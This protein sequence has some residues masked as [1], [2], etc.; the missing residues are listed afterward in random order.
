MDLWVVPT[1]QCRSIISISYI[2]VKNQAF[3]KQDRAVFLNLH[4]FVGTTNFWDGV[5]VVKT[6]IRFLINL[7]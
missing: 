7:F 2:L 3:T 5:L 1:K 6:R 4:C